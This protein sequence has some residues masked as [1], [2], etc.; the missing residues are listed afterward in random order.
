[1]PIID[2][3]ENEEISLAAF[4]ATENCVL[5]PMLYPR[6]YTVDEEGKV[7]YNENANIPGKRYTSALKFR[8]DFIS[9]QKV[10]TVDNQ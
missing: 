9:A 1:M 3:Y 10:V 5:I 8:D 2:I 4:D 6:D 7:Q